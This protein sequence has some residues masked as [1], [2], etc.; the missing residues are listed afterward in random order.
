M[1]TIDLDKLNQLKEAENFSD[2]RELE[3]S[4]LSLLEAKKQLD[5]I[6]DEVKNALKQNVQKQGLQFLEGE[7]VKVTISPTGSRYRL[8]N[9]D[10]CPPEVLEVKL[11]P[12][13]IDAY[14]ENNNK[15]PEGIQELEV[16]STAIRI[17]TK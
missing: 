2:N 4:L 1:I 3:R 5:T 11:N 8:I 16:R 7:S 9:P 14:L 17:T 6:F 12:S 10:N 13:A 15:L